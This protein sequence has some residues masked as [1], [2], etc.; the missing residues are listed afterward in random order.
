MN[1][2]KTK[3]MQLLFGTESSVSKVDPCG[4]C[5]ERVGCKSIQCIKCQNCDHVYQKI[6]KDSK[7][8]KRI[9]NDALKRNLYLYFF[10]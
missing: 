3:G 6:L 7:K 2:D 9:I 10:K 8:V 1:V 5:G 4:V